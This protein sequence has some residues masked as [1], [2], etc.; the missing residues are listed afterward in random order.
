[1][2][3]NEIKHIHGYDSPEKTESQNSAENMIDHKNETNKK[4]RDKTNRTEL[5]QNE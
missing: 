3:P 2:T 5:Q 1:M 4:T